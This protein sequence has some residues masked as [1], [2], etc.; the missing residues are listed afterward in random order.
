[1]D[2]AN[3]GD[4]VFT[5]TVNGKFRERNQDTVVA[6]ISRTRLLSRKAS[7]SHRS[8]PYSPVWRTASSLKRVVPTGKVVHSLRT[9]FWL[10]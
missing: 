10:V 3:L 4:N 1:L 2:S 9:I 6:S 8:H 7:H 5:C